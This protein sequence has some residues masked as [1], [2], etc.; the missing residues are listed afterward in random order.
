MIR[1]SPLLH[2]FICLTE[3][4]WSICSSAVVA[5]VGLPGCSGMV[6]VI[7]RLAIVVV[8]VEVVASVSIVVVVVV[9][10]VVIVVA[11]STARISGRTT[12]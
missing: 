12:E 10:V 11:W 9:V 5:G 2:S 7:P 1:P 4:D 6:V 3:G 8:V